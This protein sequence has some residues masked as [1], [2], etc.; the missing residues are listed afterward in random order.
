MSGLIPDEFPEFWCHKVTVTPADS[1]SGEVDDY[2]RPVKAASV[3]LDGWV[4]ETREWTR[5][6]DGAETLSSASLTLPWDAPRFGTG[7]TVVLPDSLEGR[8]TTVLS[9]NA[10]D[11]RKVGL[12]SVV[13]YRLA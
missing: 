2:G 5:T 13:V 6:K 4:E 10:V 3:T 9:V 1:A 12:P 11:G 8:T 7:S